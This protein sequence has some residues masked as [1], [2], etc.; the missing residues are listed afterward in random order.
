MDLEGTELNQT[1]KDSMLYDVTYMWNLKKTN[2]QK[3]KVEG[4]FHRMWV[5]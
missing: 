4:W 1:G 2:S 5:G 3:Q